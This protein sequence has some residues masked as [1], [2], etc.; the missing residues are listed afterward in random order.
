MLTN[1]SPLSSRPLANIAASPMPSRSDHDAKQSA[2]PGIPLKSRRAA[3]ATHGRASKHS[4]ECVRVLHVVQRLLARDM[5]QQK[6]G[7]RKAARDGQ[8]AVGTLSFLLDI[9]RVN[10]P[11]KRPKRGLR[12]GTLLHLRAMSWIR[13]LTARTL[14]CLIEAAMQGS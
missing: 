9:N 4:E 10:D 2:T 11:D 5:R 13:P 14:D 1:I 3:K 12:K 8:I 6:L 7:L